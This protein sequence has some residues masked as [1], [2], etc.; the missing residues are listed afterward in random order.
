M[1]LVGT[2]ETL[3]GSYM[4][5]VREAAQQAVDRAL[6]RTAGGG[7]TSRSRSKKASAPSA[8]RASR[9]T[10]AELD[11]ICD[12]LCETVRTRPG[13]TMAELA[14]QMGAQALRLQ[15]PM[16]RLKSTGRVRRVGQRHLTRYYPA[17]VRTAA[18]RD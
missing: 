3:I 6:T 5:G 8:T 2:I 16:A 10:A 17:V 12:G 7:R 9:R 14:E 11:E 18:G 1:E 13:A 15:R 4:D